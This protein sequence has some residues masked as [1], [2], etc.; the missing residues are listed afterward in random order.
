MKFT[1]LVSS[2]S[3]APKFFELL[4]RSLILHQPMNMRAYVSAL[5]DLELQSCNLSG[6]LSSASTTY[7]SAIDQDGTSHYDLKC[8][9]LC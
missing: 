9:R 2:C 7:P 1:L 5:V 8:K 4:T 6:T 3:P